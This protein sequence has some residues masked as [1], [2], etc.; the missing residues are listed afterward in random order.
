MSKPT[1]VD[2][3]IAG[4]PAAAIPLLT[5]IR[6]LIKSAVPK[7]AEG[8]SWGIPFYKYQ[9]GLA[10]FAAYKN[11]VNIGFATG[12]IDDK[13][14]AMLERKGYKTGI[15]TV[16]IKFDQ[17]IPA[18]ALKQMLQARAKMNEAKKR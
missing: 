4:A 1:D 10:G 8:I 11:H 12:K 5:K 17:T 6:E 9:G 2:G 15:R 14:R 13:D 18:A 3:Y 16:Q 7:A